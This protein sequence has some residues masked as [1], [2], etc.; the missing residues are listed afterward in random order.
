[1][2]RTKCLLCNYSNRN[3]DLFIF[4]IVS[5][6]ICL[7]SK[8]LKYDKYSLMVSEDNDSYIDINTQLRDLTKGIF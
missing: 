5:N 6:S 4:N 8:C 7:K 2:L 3:N 1:M